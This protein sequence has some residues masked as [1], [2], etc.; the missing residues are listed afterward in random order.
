MS[1]LSEPKQQSKVFLIALVVSFVV[2]GVTGGLAGWFA[3]QY[4]F[5]EPNGGIQLPFSDRIGDR[6]VVRVEE[7]SATVDAVE[8]VAPSVVSI[9]IS[10]DLS[11]LYEYRKQGF[12]FEEFFF[13]I[14]GFQFELPR[15]EPTPVPEGK[16][17][18]GSGSGFIISADGLILTNRHVVA[19]EDAEYTVITS[20][21]KEHTAQVLARDPVLD[22]AVVRIDA[23]DLTAVALGDSDQLQIGQTVIAIGN[24]L[25]EFSNS[26]TRG[27][28]SGI[29]RNIVAGDNQGSSERIE[30]AIQTDAAINPGNSGGPLVDVTGHVVGVNTAMAGGQSIGFAIPINEAKRVIESVQKHGR[31]VRPFLGVRYVLVNEDIAK[32]NNLKQDFGALVVRGEARSDLAVIPGSP[33]DKAGLSENDIILELDGTKIDENNS[34]SRL[35]ARYAPGDEIELKIM[36]DGD[37]KSVKVKLEE[38]K[39]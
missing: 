20:D 4:G 8:K 33:A 38:F 21:G 29:G 22:L 35:L 6:K 30:S 18:I 15:F 28:V 1:F 12:P 26:V 36:H 25:G 23:K 5:N 16:R 17:Q 37:E 11:K 14:P 2:G 24:A 39:E 13:D 9:V 10:K 32:E 19:D 31:I 7:E 27:I 34:L 3:G